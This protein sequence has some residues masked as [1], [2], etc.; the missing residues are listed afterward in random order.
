[1]FNIGICIIVDVQEGET[2]ENSKLVIRY[3]VYFG[4][5]IIEVFDSLEEAINF[6]YNLLNKLENE[7]NNLLNDIKKILEKILKEIKTEKFEEKNIS[8]QNPKE[9]Y[10]ETGLI[11]K[12]PP[13]EPS[14][15]MTN[16]QK[17]KKRK[18]TVQ[19]CR[20][21]FGTP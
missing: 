5:I 13:K 21:P 15:E 20:L 17:G 3:G 8:T 16:K 4:E 19:K 14:N 1:M 10:S 2:P 7:L 18:S 12:N 9:I 11:D 6:L